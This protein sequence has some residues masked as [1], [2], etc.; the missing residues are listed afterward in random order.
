V[1]YFCQ[2]FIPAWET[3]LLESEDKCRRRSSGLSTS[4][5]MTILI[6]FHRYRFRDFKTFYVQNAQAHLKG[7]FPE[8]VSYTRRLTLLQSVLVPLCVSLMQRYGNRHRLY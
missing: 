7:A 8:L 2:Q 5:V 6:L 1:G 4:E 3:T